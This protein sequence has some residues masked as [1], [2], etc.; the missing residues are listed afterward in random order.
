ML[1]LFTDTDCD[2]TPEIAD[3][4]GAGLISMPFTADET[5][6]YPF[7]ETREFDYHA[8]YDRLRNGLMPTTSALGEEKYTEIF[9][10]YF[11]AGDEIIYVHFSAAMT[12]TF[13]SMDRAL[14]KLGEKYPGV[15]FHSVDTKGISTISLA[16]FKYAGQLYKD[17]ADA[18]TIVEK[19][20]ELVDRTA[21]YFFADDLRFFHRSGRVGGLAATMGTLLGIRPII[22][23]DADGRMTSI[24]KE[25]GRKKAEA[26]L[27]S[28]MEELGEDL[29]KYPVIIGHSD[30]P[31]IAEEVAGMIREKFGNDL[32]IQIYHCNP[33]A[34]S[35]CGP[36]GVGLCFHAKHR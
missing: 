34:G 13:D 21:M 4:Y 2:V 16:V 9:E 25:K 19:T 11:A 6:V 27:V 17:G 32:D 22:Y 35:H 15:K 18:G 3:Y 5:T 24:G 36:D 31:E 33:T 12:A 8:F 23:M 14:A 29:D 26:R 10:P 20:T 1:R 28:Y 30:C 7:E